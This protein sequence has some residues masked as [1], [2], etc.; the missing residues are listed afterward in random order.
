MSHGVKFERAN[1]VRIKISR[2][3]D[4]GEHVVNDI[5]LHKQPVKLIV[6][7]RLKDQ[8]TLKSLLSLGVRFVIHLQ[9][10]FN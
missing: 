9:C 5:Y 6:S 2:R 10:T 1:C 4:G 8:D 7:N 3:C